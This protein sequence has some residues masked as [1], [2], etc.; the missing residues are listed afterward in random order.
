M[1]KV[2]PSSVCYKCYYDFQ[3]LNISSSHVINLQIYR[4]HWIA[5][6]DEACGKEIIFIFKLDYSNLIFG[7]QNYVIKRTFVPD[8][9]LDKLS[10]N[11]K[12]EEVKVF[13]H[14]YKSLI[15]HKN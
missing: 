9:R 13:Y 10:L 3:L 12:A 15:I 11:D 5:H 14:L 6:V 7:T 1:Y 4:C 2:F 8:D